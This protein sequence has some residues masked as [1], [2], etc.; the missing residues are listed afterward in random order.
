MSG[1][2]GAGK[3]TTSAKIA[4]QLKNQGYTICLVAADT[5]RAGAVKQLEEW[6]KIVGVDFF[7]GKD[8][9][10]PSSVLISAA[11]YCKE[12]NIDVMICDTAGRLQNKVNLMNELDK[13]I[14][15][16]KKEIP[17]APSE[18]LLVIDANTGQNGIN[19]AKL[20]NEI[21]NLTGVIL[22]KMDGTSKGGII[23]GIK[24]TIN[25]PVRFIGLGEKIDDL[26][27]FSIEMYLYSLIGEV[28][29]YQ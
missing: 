19:Q 14:R 26:S 3:T 23:L 24:N 15:V 12:K 5:F 13:M 29:E 4:H 17:N 18:S 20:F 22:T 27:K 16:I 10:D 2:N 9:E 21:T 28:S 25:V 7:K 11:R 6:S 8:G 1:V